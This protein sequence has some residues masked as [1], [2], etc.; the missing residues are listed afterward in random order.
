MT[1]DLDFSTTKHGLCPKGMD[2]G[3][4]LK[5]DGTWEAPPGGGD[6]T[7]AAVIADH[8]IVRGDG[9]GKGIQDSGIII[10]DDDT[11]TT[12]AQ[13]IM[14]SS[15]QVKNAA[16]DCRFYID[17]YGV[18]NWVT[19][20]LYLRV[21]NSDVMDT[22]SE[23]QPG[24]ALGVIKFLGVDTGSNFDVGA[25]IHAVQN[26]AAGV[27]IPTDLVFYTYSST[28]ANTNQL[29]LHHDGGVGIGIAN[30]L[31]Y[32]LYV[33][34][35]DGLQVHNDGADALIMVHED[36]GTHDAKMRYR[37]GSVDW[38]IGLID[39][40]NFTIRWESTDHFMFSTA[41]NFTMYSATS[42]I[43]GGNRLSL[44]AGAVGINS[45]TIRNDT[46]AASTNVHITP[47]SPG[48]FLRE[49]SAKK[50]KTK[51]KD[52]ELDS[53]LLYRLRCRSFNSL[54]GH[55][56]K[57]KR[58][59]GLI[60]D[61]VERIYPDMIHY[62]ENNEVESYDKTMLMTLMLAEEQRHEAIIQKHEKKIKELEDQLNN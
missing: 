56:D 15:S 32:K 53:S 48:Y 49:T 24:D 10:D 8:T 41:G 52:M 61:E 5:D 45:N 37:R 19:N 14:G 44:E 30:P 60:A 62:N 9:G 47:A 57:G 29:F 43:T 54:C 12:T 22:K 46:T 11:L 38:Y 35:S 55:D 34:G 50:Y 36:A 27:R 18:G 33:H 17:T 2:V 23:T 59:S 16:A 26:G 6:V 51:I 58:W 31:S 4:Y 7:A 13:I 40:A 39:S 3:A 28:A 25:V 21:S 20:E 42:T 1:I